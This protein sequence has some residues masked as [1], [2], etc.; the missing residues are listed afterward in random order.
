MNLK[1]L[2]LLERLA[3]VPGTSPRTLSL[4]AAIYNISIYNDHVLSIHQAH[5]ELK[6]RYNNPARPPDPS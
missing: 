5:S 4:P 2:H 1:I 3:R 6:I